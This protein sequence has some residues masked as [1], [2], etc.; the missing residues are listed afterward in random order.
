[1][2]RD[3]SKILKEQQVAFEPNDV[4]VLYTDGITEARYRS[5]QNGILFGVDRIVES[6]MKCDQ[7]SSVNIFQQITIDLSAFMGY[8]HK[9][10]DDVTLSVIKY[11]PTLEK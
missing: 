2:V 6:I 9:Q 3:S 4:I 7:K 5:E 11:L 1:M 10:Y 8:K